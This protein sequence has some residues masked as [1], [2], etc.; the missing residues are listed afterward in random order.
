[1]FRIRFWLCNQL[2]CQIKPCDPGHIILT[3]MALAMTFTGVCL[4]GCY[5]LMMM[6]SFVLHWAK[7]NSSWSGMTLPASISL[8]PDRCGCSCSNR[9]L[10]PAYLYFLPF[11]FITFYLYTAL[12]LYI[13]H[14]YFLPLYLFACYLYT[15]NLYT[16]TFMPFIFILLSFKSV[17]FLF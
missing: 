13:L 3:E 16:I 17:I 8:Q 7:D 10:L 4:Q 15:F 14:L 5:G 11:I 2:V 9:C 12:S 6:S 1:M